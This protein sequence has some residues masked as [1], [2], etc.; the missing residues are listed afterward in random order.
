MAL[1]H[2][3]LYSSSTVPCIYIQSILLYGSDSET[4]ALA[5]ALEGRIPAFDN[6]CLRRIFYEFPTQTMLPM[7]TYDSETVSLHRSCCRSSKQDGSIS[8]G[9]WHGWAT[10][11]ARSEPY[12]RRLT[13]CP[14]T[15]AAT[16]DI[17]VIPGYGRWQQTFSCS[18]S[19]E[20]SMATCPAQRTIEAACGNSS[21]PDR[22]SYAM[23][24]IGKARQGKGNEIS[25]EAGKWPLFP[26]IHFLRIVESLQYVINPTPYGSLLGQVLTVFWYGSLAH[27]NCPWNTKFSSV[28]V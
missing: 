7:L 24:M 26:A 11:K 6:I 12:I 21:G 25:S 14:R 9:T 16:Q 4:W 2:F 20:L 15:W 13:G 5:R 22:G 8:S 23:M 19:T 27:T 18:N 28:S 10:R 1:Q 17:H 3:C